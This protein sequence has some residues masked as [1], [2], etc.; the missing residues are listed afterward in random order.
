[1]P[2]KGGGVVEPATPPEREAVAAA[3]ALIGARKAEGRHHVA[4][5]VLTASGARHLA[6]N[7]EALLGRA[8]ICA[9]AVAIGMAAEAE[10][11][12]RIVF[13]VAVNRRGE[14]I[15]PCGGCRELL[16]DWG[17]KARIAVPTGGDPNAWEI[18]PLADLLPRAYKAHLRGLP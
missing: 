7:L 3:R 16:A 10:R 15:A 17:P 2:A 4:S 12:T 8:S 5:A 13:S 6:L 1:M 11:D 18:L 9:E 14:V